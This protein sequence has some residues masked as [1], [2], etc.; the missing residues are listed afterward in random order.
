VA[1]AGIVLAE[2][3]L[4]EYVAVSPSF[5]GPTLEPVTV[6]AGAYGRSVRKFDVSVGSVW[7]RVTPSYVVNVLKM[8]VVVTAGLVNALIETLTEV[9]AG[10]SN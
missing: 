6:I 1:P 3:I 9:F 10:H 5:V 7:S 2:V 4:S 8:P